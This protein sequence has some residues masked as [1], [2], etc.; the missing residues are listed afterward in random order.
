LNNVALTLGLI[1]KGIMDGSLIC[2][3]MASEAENEKG[4]QAGGRLRIEI[5]LE[6][7]VATPTDAPI[8]EAPPTN[9]L[10]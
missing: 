8:D 1:A 9:T 2:V 10:Q 7:P 4:L 6:E 3:Y 5:V